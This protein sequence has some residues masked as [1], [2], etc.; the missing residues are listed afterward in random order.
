M[1]KRKLK[2]CDNSD[3]ISITGYQNLTLWDI[4]VGF[5]KY[6]GKLW[7]LFE[8]D[9]EPFPL[10]S[11]HT[12]KNGTQRIWNEKP[13]DIKVKISNKTQAS[14]IFFFTLLFMLGI[15]EPTCIEI[16]ALSFLKSFKVG[17]QPIL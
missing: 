16:P 15:Y 9:R 8:R 10:F 5:L 1:L 12:N 7:Y 6:H 13:I 14:H 4:K 11:W 17:E 3:L 2:N